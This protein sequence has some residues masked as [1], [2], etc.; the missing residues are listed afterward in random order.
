MLMRKENKRKHADEEKKLKK[1]LRSLD[2]MTSQVLK[3]AAQD[4]LMSTSLYGSMH[5]KPDSQRHW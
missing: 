1:R 5:T 2:S 3:R 4:M